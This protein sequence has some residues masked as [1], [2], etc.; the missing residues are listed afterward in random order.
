MTVTPTEAALDL[1]VCCLGKADIPEVAAITAIITPLA[2][3]HW[4]GVAGDAI[5]ELEAGLLAL[6]DE[7]PTPDIDALARDDRRRGLLRELV[8][9]FLLSL[10]V[11]ISAPFSPARQ[12]AVRSASRR[13]A[14]QGARSLGLTLDPSQGPAQAAIAA[15]ERDLI[16][17]LQGRLSGRLRGVEAHVTEFLTNRAARTLAPAA[18]LP[19]LTG[20]AT[21]RQ[22]WRTQ[23]RGLLGLEGAPWVPQS[24]DVWA[25]RWFNV[26]A[27]LGARQAGVS[28]LIAVNNPPAGP[29]AR[30]TPFCRFVHGRVISI[31]RAQL[32]VDRYVRASLQADGDGMMSAWPL[33][34]SRAA[35]NGDAQDFQRS[36]VSLGLPPYHFFC[37][38]TIRAGR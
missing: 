18:P 4:E 35:R 33:L 22:A 24:V 5:A 17:I 31:G 36:F 30:T 11:G 20:A 6:E 32:Q 38:T 19:T 21:S 23:L 16:V 13:L 26:G 9:A 8:A 25:Y 28:T 7:L 1:A 27:F 14:L 12:E 3:A 29:D 34:S 37:R 15:S 10:Q 2:E